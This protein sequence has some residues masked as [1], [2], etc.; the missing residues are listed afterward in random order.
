M[1]FIENNDFSGVA[2]LRSKTI[3]QEYHNQASWLP[4]QFV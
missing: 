4:V 2:P 1:P 3:L